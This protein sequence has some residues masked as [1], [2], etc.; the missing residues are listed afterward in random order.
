MKKGERRKQELL[1]IA[2][3]MFLSKGYE[4]TSVDDII[5]EAGIAKGTYYYYFPSK[6]QTLE[7]VID[8][9]LDKETERAKAI[10]ASDYPIEQKLVGIIAS[11][12]PDEAEMTIK[13]ALHEQENLLMHEKIKNKLMDRMVP[14][15]CEVAEQ[16]IREGKF[17]CDNVP[18]RVKMI[19]ILSN[20]VFDSDNYTET[21]IAVFIDTIER[22]LYA[23]PGSMAFIAQ[24]VRK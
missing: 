11:F 13:D 21:D 6:E 4:N 5:A 23:K 1:E 20:E 18:E 15:V 12:R 7:E 24:L 2:Y 14:L 3:K 10:L 17:N 22:M 16:G 19:I 9:M 8:L